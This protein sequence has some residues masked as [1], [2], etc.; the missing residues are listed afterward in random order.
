MQMKRHPADQAAYMDTPASNPRNLGV[1]GREPYAMLSSPAAQ[2]MDAPS[3]DQ[4]GQRWGGSM[5]P[6][7]IGL[8]GAPPGPPGP[9][10][11]DSARMPMTQRSGIGAVSIGS[12]LFGR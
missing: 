12:A 5:R 2:Q 9:G 8:P 7:N 4:G 10:R 1:L 6:V 3:D 11:A